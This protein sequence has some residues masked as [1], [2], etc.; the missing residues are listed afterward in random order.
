MSETIR[1]EVFEYIR[2]WEPLEDDPESA[3]KTPDPSNV[4][5]LQNP[6]NLA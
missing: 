6:T 5:L 4:T 3:N 2:E 1:E